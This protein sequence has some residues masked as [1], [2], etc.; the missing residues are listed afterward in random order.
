MNNMNINF[1]IV[2]LC[3]YCTPHSI[4][5]A[6]LTVQFQQAQYIVAEGV[7]NVPVVIEMNGASA[8][9]VIVNIRTIAGSATSMISLNSN[10]YYTANNLIMSHF[11][12]H[13]WIP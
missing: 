10:Y 8:V 9:N 12:Q 5:P 4:P 13:Q 6:A 7:G 11:L 1:Y 2:S 3:A